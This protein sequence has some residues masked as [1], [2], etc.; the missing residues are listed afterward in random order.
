M[1]P[2]VSCL[3][4]ATD[5]SMA[6]HSN[7]NQLTDKCIWGVGCCILFTATDDVTEHVDYISDAGRCRDSD[8][9]R[10]N[11]CIHSS[12]CGNSSNARQ[13]CLCCVH[14]KHGVGVRVVVGDVADVVL[15]LE[16]HS[17]RR[18]VV[19]LAAQAAR[20]QRAPHKMILVV[21]DAC[22]DAV[23]VRPTLQCLTHREHHRTHSCMNKHTPI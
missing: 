10:L 4:K 2:S 5:W 11:C 8:Q 15:L 9:T 19:G 17:K 18:R 21:A 3:S 23:P 20:R 16:C 7:S 13:Y 1:L 6:L 22:A 14:L 12:L